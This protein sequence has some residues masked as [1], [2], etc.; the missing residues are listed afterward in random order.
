MSDAFRK[1]ADAAKLPLGIDARVQWLQAAIQ[2]GQQ[3]K[4]ETE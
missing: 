4:Q 2:A 3:I 1:Y